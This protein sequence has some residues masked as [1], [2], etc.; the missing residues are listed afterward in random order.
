MRPVAPQALSPG[1]KLVIGD[2]TTPP[3]RAGSFDLVLTPWFID[4]AGEP[5]TCLLPRINALL[6]AGGLWVKHG[7]LAFAHAAPKLAVSL[8]ELLELLPGNGF[9]PTTA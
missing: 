6:A 8:E 1:L 3:F 4:V 9:A 2:A 7:S 5:V